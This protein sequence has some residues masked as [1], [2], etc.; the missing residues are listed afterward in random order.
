MGWPNEHLRNWTEREIFQMSQEEDPFSAS[1][2]L[3][4]TSLI[5][6]TA[7]GIFIFWTEQVISH[8]L[9]LS[10][11]PFLAAAFSGIITLTYGYVVGS[12][13]LTWDL[14]AFDIA[15][16]FT[17]GLLQC[18][19]IIMIGRQAMAGHRANEFYWFVAVSAQ[20]IVSAFALANAWIKTRRER[21]KY[22]EHHRIKIY[23]AHIRNF[24]RFSFLLV[25]LMP[26][27]ILFCIVSYTDLGGM[28]IQWIMGALIAVEKCATIFGISAWDK[29][30]SQIE[31]QARADRVTPGSGSYEEWQQVRSRDHRT[32]KPRCGVP[33][34]VS[35]DVGFRDAGSPILEKA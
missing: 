17:I 4:L 5:E 14:G 8:G 32:R 15:I 29:E 19:S 33:P 22:E 27:Y 34:P 7:F 26:L 23:E 16:P 31:T 1:G 25:F 10:E 2:Y 35:C 21:Q 13:D 28:T 24:R 11:L 30:R 20:M 9:V 6:A 3:T 12:R 18:V